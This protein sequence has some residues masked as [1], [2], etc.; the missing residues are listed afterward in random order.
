MQMLPNFSPKAREVERPKRNNTE[1]TLE[2][3]ESSLWLSYLRLRG[4]EEI[5]LDEALTTFK[6]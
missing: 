4:R 2:Q 6:A 1:A 5:L 3:A